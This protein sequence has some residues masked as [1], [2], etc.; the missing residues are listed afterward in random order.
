MPY[1]RIHTSVGGETWIHLQMTVWKY[2]FDYDDFWSCFQIS[3]FSDNPLLLRLPRHP[4]M[5]IEGELYEVCAKKLEVLDELEAYPTLYD[6][7][8]IEIKLSTDGSIDHA[9]I[10]LLKSWRADLLKTSSEMMSSY[11]SLG[12]HGRQYVDRYLRAKEMLEDL[13]G[14]AANLYH[15]ILGAEHPMYLELT[16]QK[17]E[18]DLKSRE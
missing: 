17:A 15:E 8:K 9:F 10:Y 16:R 13:D 7:K 6:R 14:G 4:N 11:S 5:N 2:S 1:P 18:F 3:H 12:A